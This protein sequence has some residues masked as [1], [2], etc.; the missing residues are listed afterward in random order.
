MEKAAV[1]FNLSFFRLY[2]ERPPL[3]AG[4]KAEVGFA[5]NLGAAP[6]ARAP[7]HPHT[8]F[9]KMTP[10]RPDLVPLP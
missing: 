1:V 5:L 4:R 10:H 9:L 7:F 8:V 6:E 3:V 2:P